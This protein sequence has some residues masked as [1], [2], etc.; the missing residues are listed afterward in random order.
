VK[1]KRRKEKEVEGGGRSRR[2]GGVEEGT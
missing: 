2:E 1:G